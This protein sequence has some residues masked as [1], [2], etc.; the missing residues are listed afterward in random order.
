MVARNEP[1][2]RLNEQLGYQ[3]IPGRI[4]VERPIS[5]SSPP[6]AHVA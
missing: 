6:P 1:I 2:Q 5:G 3:P 4:V